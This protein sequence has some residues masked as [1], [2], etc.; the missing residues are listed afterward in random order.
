MRPNKSKQPQLRPL[1]ELLPNILLSN[2]QGPKKIEETMT[3]MCM[4]N[5]A[6]RLQKKM[7]DNKTITEAHHTTK[8]KLITSRAALTL[9][10]SDSEQLI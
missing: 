2:R 10:S 4:K 6:T 7:K 5:T 9:S 3:R 1:R 8:N